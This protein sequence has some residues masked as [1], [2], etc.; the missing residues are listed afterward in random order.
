MTEVCKELVQWK[1]E[2]EFSFL[3]DIPSQS[4][5]QVLKDLCKAIRE[6]LL[7]KKGFPHF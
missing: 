6:A 3:N 4:L 7:K 2:S 5:Q 1:K